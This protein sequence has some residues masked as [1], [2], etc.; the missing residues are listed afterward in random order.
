[1]TIDS[2]IPCKWIPRRTRQIRAARFAT[3][4]VESAGKIETKMGCTLRQD[5]G[6]ASPQEFSRMT[7]CDGK[8]LWNASDGFRT[9]SFRG[10]RYGSP[11]RA[12]LESRLH[13]C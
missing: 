6:A 12:W 4:V 9:P 7:C 10:L 5:N 3:E 8:N 1:M 11:P 2:Q 13:A